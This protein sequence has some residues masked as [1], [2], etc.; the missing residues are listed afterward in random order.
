LE[1]YIF[2]KNKN[3][4]EFNKNTIE[5]YKENFELVQELDYMRSCKSCKLFFCYNKKNDFITEIYNNI[6]QKLFQSDQCQDDLCVTCTN[7]LE[8]EKLEIEKNQ[9]DLILINE[10]VINLICKSCNEVIVGVKR[11]LIECCH[12]FCTKCAYKKCPT[13]DIPVNMELGTLVSIQ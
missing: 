6:Y 5:N 1:F 12:S 2:S 3:L 13:C 10:E 9:K 4:N 11:V 7:K 8:K